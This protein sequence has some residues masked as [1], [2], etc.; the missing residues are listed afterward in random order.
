VE[1][2][3]DGVL[4]RAQVGLEGESPEVR[5]MWA[6][7]VLRILLGWSFLWAFLDKMFGLGF[8]TC[9]VPD[10]GGSI[11]FLCD[12]AMIK[13]GS[14]TFGFLNFGTQ[15][16]HTG[17]LFEWMAPSAPDAINF[18]DVLF[19]LALLLGGLAL[20]LGI[21]VRIAGIGAALLMLFMFLAA[22]VWPP[23]NPVNSSHV[24]EMAAFAGIAYVG[25]GTFS[26]QSW[27][28]DTFGWSWV[29]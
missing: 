28:D 23:N 24:I 2:M 27:F 12:S 25:A 20:M 14:P 18:A 7:T 3:S 4:R 5:G 19:M 17:G 29:K 11:D 8:A 13:G 26:L 16:S 6:W 22:D 9:R 21:G 15:A 10:S 1:I